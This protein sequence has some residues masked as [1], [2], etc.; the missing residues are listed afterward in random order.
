M[1][2]L[3]GTRVSEGFVDLRKIL[4]S[5][6]PAPGTGRLSVKD[7][8]GVTTLFF[9]DSV[10]TETNL[11]AGAGTVKQIFSTRLI[12][13]STSTPRTSSI[14]GEVVKSTDADAQTIL[15]SAITAVDNTIFLVTNSKTSTITFALNDDGVDVHQVSTTSGQTGEFSASGSVVVAAG[16][17]INFT[18][19]G[20]T[21]IGQLDYSLTLE[22]TS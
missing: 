9:S 18:E 7:L 20:G 21:S 15:N 10:G 4:T 22:Y 6:N 13:T 3:G 12:F 8:V 11:L 19:D 14:F 2:G 5:S 17:K 1:I 16:S